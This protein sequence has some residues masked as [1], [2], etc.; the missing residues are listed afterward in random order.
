MCRVNKAVALVG[1]DDQ[2]RGNV[3][4]A[5]G[6]PEFKGLGSRTFAVAI[7]Y[8]RK[9]GRGACLMKVMGELLA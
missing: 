1:V 7:A 3:E 5:Q 4:I 9:R 8:D 2:L 6:M